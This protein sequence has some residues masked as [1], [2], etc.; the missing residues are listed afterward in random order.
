VVLSL[1]PENENNIWVAYPDGANGEKVFF[2]ADGGQQWTNKTTAAL[3]DEHISYIM[4]QGGT[5]GVYLGTYR[6]VWY[7]DN[8]QADWV[9][10]S[11]G[12]P[13]SIATCILRPFYRDNKIRLGAYGKGVW[14]TNFVTPSKPVA[15]P[16]VNKRVTDCPGDTLLFDDYSML[17]HAGASWEW[18]FPGGT[19]A[20]SVLR[21]PRVVY[22]NPG[23][24]DVTL[25][26]TNPNGTS[27]KTVAKMVKVLDPV[28]SQL[29]VANDFS[30]GIGSFTIVNPDNGVTWEPVVLNTCAAEGDTAYFVNNYIY[31]SYGQDEMVLPINLDLTSAVSA[32]LHFR[33][34][35][36]PYYDGG[37]FI[38]SLKVRASADCG[39]H[40]QT[41]FRSGGEALST[42]TSGLGPGNL[43]EY[44]AFSPQNCDE[45]RD[46]VL[47]LTP[48]A[49]KYVTI[50][51]Q[52]QSGYGNNMYLDDIFINAELVSG[53]SNITKVVKFAV[54]PNI[55]MANAVVSGSSPGSTTLALSL[56]NTTGGIVWQKVMDVQAG[57]WAE[58]I[59]MGSLP[60][61]MYWLKVVDA[62]GFSGVQ[63]VYVYK[64]KT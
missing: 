59:S 35:Y 37:F 27:T 12:L 41:I 26:V 19:P 7:R 46:T 10:L 43:Y 9:P 20:A 31:S 50:K 3:N 8:T 5:S 57:K 40:F 48:F 51:F 29:P 1:D 63:K 56:V 45:W 42:T 36:A 62:N 60:A 54:Q 38:D 28:I 4:V 30:A 33:V 11:D 49:G 2:S 25:T 21:N 17:S 24:Y 44:D 16:M 61:G 52:N 53:A 34:A 58:N 6:T 47:D 14:E 23:E 18:K 64:S 55:T 15:Q 13:E 32:G 22:Q 39:T